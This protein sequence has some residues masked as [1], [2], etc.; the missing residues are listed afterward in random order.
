MAL[1]LRI[2]TPSALAFSGPA[3]E[4]QAPGVDGEFGVLEGHALL[5]SSLRPGVV[6]VHA[7]AERNRFF[8]SR[9][10][11]EVGPHSVTLI[12]ESCERADTVDKAAAAQTLH[13]VERGLL[14]AE[15]DS[16]EWKE[17]KDAQELAAARLEV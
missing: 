4:V 17:L 10:F 13:E 7:G 1:E 12:V 8:V 6:T 15:V 16:P 5:L 9:G 14:Q 2:V 11:A 3:E